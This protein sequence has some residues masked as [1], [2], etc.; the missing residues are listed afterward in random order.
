MRQSQT[1]CGILVIIIFNKN[2]VFYSMPAQQLFQ[3]CLFNLHTHI[4]IVTYGEECW[5][6]RKYEQNQ[7][8][9]T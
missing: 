2:G 4:F 1:E 6:I 9:T 3:C 5:T 8:N 7:L